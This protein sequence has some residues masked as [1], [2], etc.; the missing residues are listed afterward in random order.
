MQ[1]YRPL[2]ITLTSSLAFVFV[3]WMLL[4]APVG[5]RN[6][7]SVGRSANAT[8]R[9][10]EPAIRRTAWTT[11]RVVGSPDPAPPYRTS[12]A[13]PNLRFKN[14]VVLAVP[15]GSD[16]MWVGEQ[17]GKVHS[18][19]MT[20]DAAAPDLALD[21]ESLLKQTRP[22]TIDNSK[23]RGLEALYGLTFHP[24][25]AENRFAYV[26][27]VVRG[28]GGKQLPDGTR[29][30]RFRVSESDPPRLEPDSEQIVITWLQGGHNGG[31]L[32]F[33]PDG[34][35]YVSTGDG[36][37]A[38]PPDGLNS[39]QD[40]TNL[41]SSVLRIDVDHPDEGRGYSIPR[42]N[43]F[44]DLRGARGE[45]WCYGLRNPWKMS[46]DRA[47]GDLW[48]GD[49]GWELW[50]LVYKV[51]RGGNYGWSVV[52]GR[53]PVHPDRKVGPTPILPPTV[54]I[55]HT[56]GVSITGGYVYRGKKFPELVGTY[57]FGDWETRRVWGVRWDE[58]TKS[59]SPRR[60]LLDPVVRLVALTEDHDGELF[61][62]D[63]DDGTI[64]ELASN[65]RR[66]DPADFPRRLSETGL[67]S[68]TEK[69]QPAPGAVPFSVNVEQWA[70]GA[71]AEHFIALPGDRPV[72]FLPKKTAI[73]GSMFSSSMNY[74]PDTVLVKTIFVG[75][76]AGAGGG[77]DAG[78]GGDLS[79]HD[80]RVRRADERRRRVE[81]QLLHFDG[82][83]WRG[84]SYAWNEQQTDAT[85]VEPEGR[86]AP[87]TRESAGGAATTKTGPETWHFPSRMECAR[88]HNQWAEYSLAFNL[89]QLNRDHDYG[90]LAE[91]QL[92][93]LTSA[94]LVKFTELDENSALRP[95]SR[96][97][98]RPNADWFRSTQPAL[99]NPYDASA[100]LNR[101]ARSY[102]HVNCAH[103]HRLGGGGTAYIELQEE[104]AL[105]AM[106]AIDVRPTQGAF[107]IA[108]ARIVATGD[109]YRST[110]Y[111][112]VSKTG[113][114]RMPHIGSEIVDERGARLIHDWIRQLPVRLDERLLVERLQA[115]DEATASKR[116]ADEREKRIRDLA[117]QL[118]QR[119]GPGVEVTDA[120]RDEAQK[121]DERQTAERRA[122][123]E[124][125]RRESIESLLGDTSRAL[126][127]VDSLR[128]QA[129]PAG[130]RSELLAAASMHRQPQIRDLFESF[131]PADQRVKR[132][133]AVVKPDQ[134][135]SLSGDVERGRK[136]YHETAGIQCKNCHRIGPAGSN[137][138]PEL[139]TI[140]KK[141]GRAQLLEQIL[142]PSKLID[143]KYVGYVI[144]TSDGRLLT[145]RLTD[146]T[147]EEF[148]L[149]DTKDQEVRIKSVEVEALAPM[150]QSLM[151]ELQLRDM[152]AQQVADLLEYLGTLK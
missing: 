55:P 86:D 4:D 71:T 72:E 108:D 74:P 22:P 40:L 75:A 148:V 2:A 128:E 32:A 147:D 80:G 150:R 90:G 118:A 45:I 93:A 138:G 97:G 14:P 123:R 136:L 21:V 78:D 54:E 73:A 120:D 66:H 48:V 79:G 84:Y 104:L 98:F 77:A 65:D 36:G 125:T 131:L 26:C 134:I 6:G 12:N 114:G 83:F 25:F 31:C 44:V 43:P 94:G 127:A 57:V 59:A 132:L 64:H 5:E 129:W 20:R 144:E 23:V 52:E 85:L 139:T 89:R 29:V 58:A 122:A 3:V 15:P 46:F 88:C 53:Q 100:D 42:D 51:E 115:A 121:Q 142:E 38:N 107:E 34:C 143:P 11:S 95:G 8:R 126:R 49:V 56:D 82:R 124:K 33:G 18:F 92:H 111:Y 146:R 69:H 24:K 106:K 152:T 112:R 13:F 16:R 30:S 141:Y 35:L 87:L 41:L 62:L 116:E 63:Y 101:R 99:V 119:R 105:D 102:L 81:T 70:D 113:S 1:T 47:T 27:Y 140:G 110:L 17:S 145:G 103:C 19:R 9:P 151:P 76:G 68:S 67:F 10:T 37:F 28:E 109:P 61:L 137:L 130:V 96:P 60:D 39:G 135:L 50:E 133:G 91:N 149:R 117:R 7:D